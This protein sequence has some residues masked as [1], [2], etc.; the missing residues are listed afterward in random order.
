[1][2]RKRDFIRLIAT[3]AILF[4]AFAVTSTWAATEK[5][6]YSFNPQAKDGF[7]PYAGLIGDT[8]GNFYGTTTQG[9]LYSAGT[10]FELSPNGS[11]GWTE[12]V[13]H[14][15]E[16]N[17]IDGFAPEAALTLDA[18]GNL[19]GTTSGGGGYY[20]GTVFELSPN[21]SGGWTETVLYS[22]N[23]G[24]GTDGASPYAGLI[25]DA[26]GNLYGTT[27]A[28]GT[29]GA[30]TVFELSPNGSGG[31]TETVLYSF[32]NNDTD[33]QN[34]YAG[35]I[36]DGAGNLYGTTYSGGTYGGGTVFELSPNGG[37]G[38][39]ETVLHTF[40]AEI[41]CTDGTRLYAGMIFDGAGNLYGT[42]QSGGTYGS[43]TVFELFPRQGEGWPEE[44]LY[45]FGHA[46]D[47]KR[48]YAGLISDGAGNFYGTTA[49]GGTHNWGTAFELFPNG[50]GG[51]TEKV[52]HNFNSSATD[53]IT[54][55]AVL[56]RDVTGN[57]YGTTFA[58]GT[59]YEGTVFELSPN[60]S[61]WTEK[62]LHSFSPAGTDGAF[63]QGSLIFDANGNL[64][65][66][67]PL[68]GTGG[69]GTVFELS[70]ESGGWTEKTLLNFNNKD[71]ATAFGGLIFDHAGNLYG[72]TNDGGTHYGYGN[73]FELSPGS[74]G[75][76]EKVLYNFSTGTDANSPNYESLV[77]DAAGNLYGTTI[78]G[79]IYKSGTVF[80]LTPNG[81]GG[82][83]EKVLYS[84]SN[85]G[86]DGV[87]PLAGIVFDAA[88]NLYGT[89]N[90]GGTD[91]VGTVFELSPNG[92]GGW[93]EKLLHTF[94]NNGADGFLP[95]SGL[96]F[97]A[98]GNLYGTTSQ[99]GTYGVGTIF[100]LSPNGSGGW[101]ETVLYNF[102]PNG[103]DGF[104][105]CA[106]LIFDAGGNLY[107]TTNQG[108]TYGV[109]TVF[110]LSP[111]S[112][113][114]TETVLYSFIPNGTDGNNPYSSLIFDAAGNLYGTTQNGGT[115]NAG[116]VYEIMP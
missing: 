88:G 110:E 18:H 42:T 48:P 107:G 30:G 55:Y 37:G 90:Q 69:F 86:T 13:L 9:G 109:G 57:L 20:N 12:K 4:L 65:G 72:T 75:W 77:F 61:A 74:G 3:V 84:F 80:E 60:G 23:P 89:T 52:L 19:Y 16:F 47:G 33:G 43:G 113:G 111:G 79:G 85:N 91:G 71:G 92:S 56:I 38:W 6:L 8:A 11:G 115:D 15:F 21:G 5:V 22:F 44:V 96:I 81:H 45:S 78:F 114:W 29:Y 14:D 49:S 2:H 17:G 70:P 103:T 105:P 116:T 40:C 102:I 67:T 10:V 106:G 24:N 100:E 87:L 97:D 104:L 63:P 31:W 54:P 66:Q 76:T 28:G 50:K 27:V 26:Q 36:F 73:V 32:N 34:P 95:Q 25:F 68:S 64:Y 53:G 59:Y 58:D 98:H 101:T 1:M 35:V 46:T 82:W 99:G 94:D 83:A 7:S 93:T 51:W 41:N 112:G 62:V 39:K 108:G